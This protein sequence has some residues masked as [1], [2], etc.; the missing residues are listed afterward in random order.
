MAANIPTNTTPA[1]TPGNAQAAGAAPVWTEAPASATLRVVTPQGFDV[2]LT[3][4]AGRMSDLLAQL[5]TLETWLSEHGWQP[6]PTRST[7]GP[8]AQAQDA[9]QAETPPLCA[10]HKTPMTKRTKDGRSW[11]SCNEKLDTG[12]WCP[13]RPKS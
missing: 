2:L 8:A 5:A 6:A 7:G 11:W 12:E 9:G 1:P 4:R 10:I 3:S 13:Y